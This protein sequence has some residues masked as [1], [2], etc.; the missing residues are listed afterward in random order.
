MPIYFIYLLNIGKFLIWIDPLY[1][2]CLEAGTKR[3]IYCFT[4]FYEFHQIGK[5]ELLFH[6]S[7][8]G[9][10]LLHQ[11]VIVD[12]SGYNSELHP[13]PVQLQ[14]LS[15]PLKRSSDHALRLATYAATFERL[16]SLHHLLTYALPLLSL[17]RRTII[18]Y[19]VPCHR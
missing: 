7:L 11:T 3:V 1:R 5:K 9:S 19:H 16:A 17:S 13:I 15:H 4:Y 12:A 6:Q 14:V 18:Y 2:L 10:N 8:T